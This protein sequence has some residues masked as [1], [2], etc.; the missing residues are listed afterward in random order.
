MLDMV[1]QGLILAVSCTNLV[2]SALICRRL[3]GEEAEV[4]E[5]GRRKKRKKQGDPQLSP[6]EAAIREW[7]GRK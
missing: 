7:T 5:D 1:L 4:G 2:I 6:H 3:S